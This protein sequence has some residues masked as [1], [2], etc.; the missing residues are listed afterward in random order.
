MPAHTFA[1][2]T[3]WAESKVAAAG[4]KT[5]IESLVRSLLALDHVNRYH[6]WGAPLTV[7]APNA[8]NFNFTGN[9]RR[10]WQLV[11]KTIGW[12]TVDLPGPP[13]D[14]WHFT[15]YIAPPTRKPFALS[16]LDL[17]FV[18]HPDF[19]E[20]AN[21]EYLRRFLPDS[22]ER[23]NHIITISESSRDD[24][25]KEYQL[26]LDKV[27]VTHLAA[28]PSFARAVTDQE[29]SRIK[30]K[31]G[32]EG[33]YFLAVGTLEPRKNLK[34]LF[35]AFAASR[36]A[37]TEQLVVVGGQ[38]WLFDET[39]ALLK[40][41][42][43]GS[44]V[45]LTGYV[46]KGE[47]PVLYSGAKLFVFPSHYEGFGM[48]VLEAML[49]GTPVI[50]SNTSSM[51]EVGGAAALYFDPDDTKALRLALERVLTDGDLRMRLADAGREQAAK[52]SWA[53]TARKTLGVYHKALGLKNVRVLD[54][55]SQ[56]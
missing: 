30:E 31:Y 35:L 26:P 29:S 41:L 47:L 28:D 19:T 46:P 33:D 9:Y 24:L 12:P 7:T 48:P 49:A 38:G 40:K 6:L 37:T 14:L 51:P 16:V 2:D 54:P 22:L 11:W 23:A 32:I 17:S 44:R 8:H 15:N 53:E 43:L 21:L 5:Y 20:P 3:R 18:K 25:I 13:A 27:T 4:T 45:I 56:R 55:S 42:G 34:N 50:C 1:I 39:E 52:F 10:A 36:K